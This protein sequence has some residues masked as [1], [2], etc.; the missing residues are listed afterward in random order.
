[1]ETNNV[2]TRRRQDQT[3]FISRIGSKVDTLP[4]QYSPSQLSAR[5]YPLTL[6]LEV[7]LRSP[8]IISSAA[9]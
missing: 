3:D 5:S 6:V 7:T 1:M 8:A 2:E 9:Y 4:M